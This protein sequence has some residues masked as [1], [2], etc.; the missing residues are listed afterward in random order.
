MLLHTISLYTV[1]LHSTYVLIKVA[2]DLLYHG[3]LILCEFVRCVKHFS[4]EYIP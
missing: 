3:V 4:V 2:T 1:R